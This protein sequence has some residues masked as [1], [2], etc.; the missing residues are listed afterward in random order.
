MSELNYHK[1]LNIEIKAPDGD[2][3]RAQLNRQQDHQSSGNSYDGEVELLICPSLCGV[4][5]EYESDFEPGE[6]EEYPSADIDEWITQAILD[7]WSTGEESNIV[8]GLS[9]KVT[10]PDDHDGANKPLEALVF[11]SLKTLAKIKQT[12]LDSHLNEVVIASD[13]PSSEY[14]KS[15]FPDLSHMFHI[16]SE[17]SEKAL[18]NDLKSVSQKVFKAA[19]LENSHSRHIDYSQTT[20]RKVVADIIPR[21]KHLT[22]PEKIMLTQNTDDEKSVNQ[23]IGDIDEML[24]DSEFEKI[25]QL[26]KTLS[27]NSN[28]KRV[29]THE[30]L[31]NLPLVPAGSSIS[32][33]QSTINNEPCEAYYFESENQRKKLLGVSVGTLADEG[34]VKL[35]LGPDLE[36]LL[37]HN[38]DELEKPNQQNNISH[39]L[40][41]K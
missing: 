36:N 32:L 38:K 31:Q 23:W 27:A 19:V 8:P 35:Y 3:Y 14:I 25:E 28:V 26:A 29:S 10:N 34:K 15:Q 20:P 24:Y 41:N 7:G 4:S 16:E 17:P 30:V 13:S 37:S 5:W 21:L 6:M 33:E 18:I 22:S 2:L 12:D 1:P 40:K 11:G 9:F 39:S